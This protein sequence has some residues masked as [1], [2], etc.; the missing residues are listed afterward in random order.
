MKLTDP[1]GPCQ[2]VYMFGEP[3]DIVDIQIAF[4]KGGER[5]REVAVRA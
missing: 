2:I 5:T 1:E 3:Q 4:Y